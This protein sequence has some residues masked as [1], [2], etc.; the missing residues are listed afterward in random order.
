MHYARLHVPTLG[1]YVVTL[2]LTLLK[3][4][5]Y[6]R[7]NPRPPIYLPYLTFPIKTPKQSLLLDLARD[8]IT[9]QQHEAIKI[10]IKIKTKGKVPIIKKKKA[11]RRGQ[12]RRHYYRHLKGAFV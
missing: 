2:T 7:T 11:W 10:E 9:N 3:V 8:D 1:T 4:P 12:G 6:L 5:T